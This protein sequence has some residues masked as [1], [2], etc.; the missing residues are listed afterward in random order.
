MKSIF[1]LLSCTL[2]IANTVLGMDISADITPGAETKATEWVQRIVV[3]QPALRSEIK[4][5][6]TISFKAPGMDIAS[7]FCWQQPESMQ[8]ADNGHDTVVA[9]NLSVSEGK[10]VSFLFPA[11]EYPHGP[12]SI[13]ILAVNQQGQ[14]DRFELQLYNQGG[15]KWREG[16]PDTDPEASEGMQLVF[17]DDFDGPLSISK[18]GKGTLYT[19]HKPF[20]GDFGE[21]LFGD[22]ESRDNPFAQQHTYLRIRTHKEEGKP[23]Y[24]G[25]ISAARPNATGIFVRAPFYMECRFV[26]LAAPGTWPAFWTLSQNSLAVRSK[27]PDMRVDQ[28][29][30]DIIEAYGGLGEGNPNHPG[31]T[32]TTHWWF[33]KDQNGEKI[34][35]VHRR[36]PMMEISDGSYWSTTFHTYGVKVTKSLTTYYMDSIPVFEH[37]TGPVSQTD[38]HF[39]MINYAIGGP[40]PVDLERYDNSCDMWVDYVRVYEGDRL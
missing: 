16:I 38:G 29:E 19:S 12:L 39:F 14:K 6:T 22:L 7:V 27:N 26:A 3:E 34:K 25:L 10:T 30:L 4:G 18:E 17:E 8:D 23:G 9:Q 20:G 2:V 35:P 13:R 5:D 11:D 36:L 32:I 40:W 21:W 15:I 33:Q 31:Y 28:D 37:P 1:S 24:C